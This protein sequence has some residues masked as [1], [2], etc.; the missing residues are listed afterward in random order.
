M[1]PHQVPLLILLPIRR[2]SSSCSSACGYQSGHIA[3]FDLTR[4]GAEVKVLPPNDSENTAPACHGAVPIVHLRFLKEGT[5]FVSGDVN[6]S[7]LWCF[8]MKSLLIGFM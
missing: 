2:C 5:S 1:A 3:V 7:L 6:G 8:A 4:D